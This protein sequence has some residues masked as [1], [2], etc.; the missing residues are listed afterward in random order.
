MAL[1]L[2]TLKPFPFPYIPQSLKILRTIRV[3]LGAEVTRRWTRDEEEG[4]DAGTTCQAAA[5]AT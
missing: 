5:A 3:C 1:T 2:A 4:S